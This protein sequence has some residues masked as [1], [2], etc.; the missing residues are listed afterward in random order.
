MANRLSENK[1]WKVLLLEAGRQE[2][3]LTD[4]PLTASANSATANNW[5]Y[6]TDPNSQEACLGL[7]YVSR[8]KRTRTFKHLKILKI[9]S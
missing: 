2:T 9:F 6:R 8:R 3:F 7:E 4:V 5:G 1:K